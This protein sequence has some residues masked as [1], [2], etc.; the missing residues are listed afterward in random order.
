MNRV[1]LADVA[2]EAGVSQGAVSLI[3]RERGRFSAETRER[4]L[5]VVKQVGYRPNPYLSAAKTGRFKHQEAGSTV[6]IALIWKGNPPPA[7][8]AS[9]L[10]DRMGYRLDFFDFKD[11]ASPRAL[12]DLLYAR[13]YVAVI[14]GQLY[15]VKE[16]PDMGLER[17][18][19]ICHSRPFFEVPFDIVRNDISQ[20]FI[21]LF[22]LALARGY[23]RIGLDVMIHDSWERS[24]PDDEVR[25]ASALHCQGLIPES[26]R[27]P[28]HCGS[29]S[30]SE[31][32][33]RWVRDTRPDLV[34]GCHIARFWHLREANFK[35]PEDFAF[36][37]LEAP[38]STEL[39]DVSGWRYSKENNLCVA[40]KT[41]DSK[42]RHNYTN[43]SERQ[44]HLLSLPEWKEGTTFPDLSAQ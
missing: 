2:R 44:K 3:L 14:M 31:S 37:I 8:A 11:Y 43:S 29:I 18:E 26:E 39:P 42:I 36:A 1:T 17:F 28:L 33:I 27:L 9:V 24:H 41:L 38:N 16:L 7:E 4:V 5:A 6:P 25:H 22:R 13:G 32:F 23:R 20:S 21:R 10:A 30:E 19:V 35:V 34:I 12:G 40:V 15:G